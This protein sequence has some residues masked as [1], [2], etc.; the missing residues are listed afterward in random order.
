MT[1]VALG[2]ALAHRPDLSET[3]QQRIRERIEEAIQRYSENW[4]S[5]LN[6]EGDRLARAADSLD[7]ALAAIVSNW[8]FA[9][10]DYAP[11]HD[12]KSALQWLV[13][14]GENSDAG[15]PSEWFDR[16]NDWTARSLWLVRKELDDRLTELMG[17]DATRQDMHWA[18]PLEANSRLPENVCLLI[19]DLCQI[20]HDYVDHQLGLPPRDP[21]PDNPLL[22]FIDANL[23]TALGRQ[24][25]SKKKVLHFVTNWSRP[26]IREDNRRTTSKSFPGVDFADQIAALRVHDDEPI[27]SE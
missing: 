11:F 25:P 26:A 5:T 17:Y 24:R 7:R 18:C 9:D 4:G 2:H 22:R 19:H 21:C 23:E 12:E 10:D 3:V 13:G 1:E 20:W 27:F 15:E 16:T 8:T 14:N 6:S